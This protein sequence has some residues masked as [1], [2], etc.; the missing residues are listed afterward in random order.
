M[1]GFSL[2]FGRD[3][4]AL[5]GGILA[6]RA[7]AFHS[8]FHLPLS[9]ELGGDQRKPKRSTSPLSSITEHHSEAV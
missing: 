7:G 4:M 9:A 6:G 3:K 8:G 5:R 1:M 2:D